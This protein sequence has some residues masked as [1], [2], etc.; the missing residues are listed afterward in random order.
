MYM[1]VYV[2]MYQVVMFYY[3]TVFNIFTNTLYDVNIAF[4]NREDKW[5]NVNK[6]RYPLPQRDYFIIYGNDAKHCW[7]QSDLNSVPTILS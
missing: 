2:R 7:R 1:H 4:N 3:H 6:H 5:T